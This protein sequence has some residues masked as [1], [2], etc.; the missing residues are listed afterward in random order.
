MV[1]DSDRIFTSNFIYACLATLAFFTAFVLFF[2]TLP[3][4]I[5]E[6]G[7]NETLIGLLVGGS[8][9]VS[10][11][12]RPFTG[13]LVDTLGRRRF[14]T[15]GC[16]LLAV[17]SMGYDFVTS[18]AGLWPVRLMAGAGVSFYFTASMAY[19]ADIA[20]PTK[21]GQAKSYFGMFTNV[22]MATG[23][24]LGTWLITSGRVAG[25]ESRLQRWLPGSGSEVSDEFNFAILFV[26]ASAIAL[27][28]VAITLRL[29]EVHVPVKRTSQGLR[30]TIG[31][32]FDKSAVFPAVL[33]F[34][35]V[36]NFV[37]LNIFIPIYNK[38]ELHLGN[39]G[40]YYT[41]LAVA[42]VLSRVWGGTLLDRFPRAYAIV[43]AMVLIMVGTFSIAIVQE[44]WFIFVSAALVGTGTGIA[45]PGLQAMMVD[46][47]KPVNFGAA[48]STFAIGLDVGLAGGGA[49]M[50][51][52]LAMTNF[53]TF[54]I[55]SSMFPGAAAI[56]LALHAF[57]HRREAAAA[58]PAPAG[59]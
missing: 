52:I 5:E 22:A 44:P 58:E 57:R 1:Q 37:A 9:L 25:I 33:N 11:T 36:L 31:S 45:Q 19:V 24:A 54:F 14:L 27:I 4:F 51:L 23:Q 32:L 42:I 2:P 17:S 30:Q 41:V 29:K 12:L 43:P 48:S 6:Q 53:T 16:A 46:R 21:R 38:R 7:G 10:L 26:V 28:G 55:V 3:I 18:T 40:L 34:M 35:I 13:R 50:G 49:L 39:I 15:L 59:G 56:I 47:A 8:S 20:P